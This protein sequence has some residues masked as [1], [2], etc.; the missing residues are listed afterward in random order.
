[1]AMIETG[2]LAYVVDPPAI[3]A[4]KQCLDQGKGSHMNA[5]IGLFRIINCSSV[6]GKAR[7]GSAALR[8]RI[9][10]DCLLKVRYFAPRL[11]ACRGTPRVSLPPRKSVHWIR[12]HSPSRPQN[13]GEHC[14]MTVATVAVIHSGSPRKS[15][16]AETA[17]QARQ[18]SIA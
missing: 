11:C 17:K 1:M 8:Q 3:S 12:S 14:G 2:E 13:P 18:V 10:L 7:T 6:T 16:K 4:D 5:S 9:A 15:S